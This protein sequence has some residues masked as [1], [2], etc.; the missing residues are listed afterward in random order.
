MT[1]PFLLAEKLERRVGDTQILDRIDLAVQKGEVVGLIGPSGS[2]KSSLLRCIAG[3]DPIT[4]GRVLVEG[5]TP[6]PGD[7]TIGMVFQQFNL[8]PHLTAQENVTL[9]LRLV[10]KQSRSEAAERARTMLDRVDLL[11]FADRRPAQLSGGQQQ[12]VA[13]ARTLA[14]EPRLVLFDEP[15]ASL[16]PELTTEVL[17]VIRGLADTGMTMLVVSHEMGFVAS[18]ATRAVFLDHGRILVDGPTKQVFRDAQEPRLRRFL[19]TYLQRVA[20]APEPEPAT[21]NPALLEIIENPPGE[22]MPLTSTKPGA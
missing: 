1:A 2:G 5:R 9:A 15:T 3:L 18:V 8:W 14:M 11:K 19:A 20:W 6:T 12:R 22:G 17:D 7:G 21:D 4:G 10:R 16:D 13:I